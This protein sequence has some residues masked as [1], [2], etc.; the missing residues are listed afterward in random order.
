MG[1]DIS[2]FLFFLG[3]LETLVKEWLR[4]GTKQ[5][6]NTTLRLEQDVGKLDGRKDQKTKTTGGGMIGRHRQK[7][8]AVYLPPLSVLPSVQLPVSTLR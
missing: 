8:V 3:V 6:H 7:D 2:A 1:N 5:Q 4:I